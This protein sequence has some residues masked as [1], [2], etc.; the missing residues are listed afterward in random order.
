MRCLHKWTRKSGHDKHFDLP[1]IAKS[2]GATL[3]D[4]PCHTLSYTKPANSLSEAKML[5]RQAEYPL[6]NVFTKKQ[7]TDPPGTSYSQ[8]S[9]NI[10][11]PQADNQDDALEE[12]RCAQLVDEH[13]PSTS[14][15]STDYTGHGIGISTDQSM[16]TLLHQINGKQDSLIESNAQIKKSI[17]SLKTLEKSK[18]YTAPKDKIYLTE[19]TDENLEH[20]LKMLTFSTP[21]EEILDNVLIKNVFR[22]TNQNRLICEACESHNVRVG[23][24]NG[25]EFQDSSYKQDKDNIPRWFSKMNIFL[26]KH[27]NSESHLE[28][29]AHFQDRK[30][31]SNHQKI[32]V[33]K[34]MRY[35][36]YYL[37]HTNTAFSLWPT[38]LGIADRCGIAIGNINHSFNFVTKLTSHINTILKQNTV[39]WFT[40]QQNITVTLDIGTFHGLALLVTIYIGDNGVTKLTGVRL[41]PS[42]GGRFLAELCFKT[43]I[44]DSEIPLELATEKIV[45]V[46]ADGA[47]AKENLPFKNRFCELLQN[48]NLVFKWDILHLVNRAHMQARGLTSYEVEY[49]NIVNPEADIDTNIDTDPGISDGPDN[50]NTNQTAGNVCIGTLTLT[51]LINYVQSQSK[52]WRSGVKYTELVID[53]LTKFKRPKVWSSTRMSVYEFDQI[54]RFLECKTYW[55]VPWNYEVLAQVHC[56]VLFALRIM[57]RKVQKTDVSATYVNRV[58]KPHEGLDPDGKQAMKLALNVAKDVANGR[59]VLYLMDNDNQHTDIL[60]TDDGQ[61]DVTFASELYKFV[62]KNK[63]FLSVTDLV[64]PNARTRGQRNETFDDITNVVSNF[65]DNFWMCVQTRMSFTNTDC[66]ITSFSEAP[67][68]SFF[69]KW[70]FIIDHRPSLSVDNIISLCRIMLEG[71][72]PSTEISHDLT[73]KALSLWEGHKGERFTTQKWSGLGVSKSVRKCQNKKWKFLEYSDLS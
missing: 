5:K 35:L 41:T 33:R 16:I 60:N 64:N 73:K 20:C 19:N 2:H 29:N 3:S 57:L 36:A 31:K 18:S 43:I 32:L 42:K 30:E 58:F 55:D 28:F 37:I 4:N 8:K 10:D 21:M 34:S 45:G 54:F 69:S 27:C 53:S 9:Q 15:I 46:V 68:E 49:E 7:R 39:V 72:D 70:Q 47:F 61:E 50:E 52:K 66:E 25:I 62:N 14:A 22:Q 6:T 11:N 1:K 26:V 23:G 59:S 63:S 67:A 38:L 65:I 48:P 13:Q 71:P 24:N 12:I 40:A 56:H 44:E 51:E 17:D